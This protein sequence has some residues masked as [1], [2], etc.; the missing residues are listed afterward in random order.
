VE[1]ESAKSWYVKGPA[2]RARNRRR[3]VRRIAPRN[4]RELAALNFLLIKPEE[5][6]NE[7]RAELLGARAAHVR[8]AHDLSAGMT[9]AAVVL[10]GRR[11]RAKVVEL[12]GD[13]AVLELDLEQEP[14]P[15]DPLEVIVAVPRPQTIK[16]VLQIAATTGLGSVH[17]LKT[18]LVEKSYLQSKMLRPREIEEE[19]FKGVEQ[20]GDSRLPVI[21]VH[22]SFTRFVREKLPGLLRSGPVALVADTAAQSARILPEAPAADRSFVLAIG[23]EAGWTEDE[24]RIFTEHGFAAVSLGSRMLRVDTAL[25]LLIGRVQEL[26]SRHNSL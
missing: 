17:F 6:K 21:E 4:I 19:L 18:D 26:R 23:P 5:L 22:A 13:H 15:R 12:N 14:A 10:G 24:R 2:A 11:G 8:G 16:K 25:A 3:I 9:V 20:S 1:T 7:H